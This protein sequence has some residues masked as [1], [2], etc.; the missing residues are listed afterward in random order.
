M[1]SEVIRICA[2]R[3]TNLCVERLWFALPWLTDTHTHSDSFQPA[4]LLAQP[5]EL[6]V[7]IELQYESLHDERFSAESTRPDLCVFLP[8]MS[9]T[10]TLFI[11][12]FVTLHKRLCVHVW[13]FHLVSSDR[14]TDSSSELRRLG[15]PCV[16]IHHTYMYIHATCKRHVE[17]RVD[18]VWLI[19]YYQ[20]E[21]AD[22][23]INNVHRQAKLL[24]ERTSHRRSRL[25]NFY[26]KV[27][28]TPKKYEQYSIGCWLR[29]QSFRNLSAF[30]IHVIQNCVLCADYTWHVRVILDCK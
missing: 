23:R 26:S 17:K 1:W 19:A 11:R 24:Y 12:G 7:L 10:V 16:H 3:I 13:R 18:R 27:A 20:T 4:I 21:L 9:M 22:L 28:P 8:T 15:S 29:R 6:Q 2:C 30:D 5:A 25:L 14:V